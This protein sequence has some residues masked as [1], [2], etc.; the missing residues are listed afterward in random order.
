MQIAN[1]RDKQNPQTNQV[2]IQKA[3]TLAPTEN[4]KR[5]HLADHRIQTSQDICLQQPQ[6][7]SAHPSASLW[8]HLPLAGS[9]SKRTGTQ[10]Y[11]FFL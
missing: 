10:V 8:V 7:Q 2:G 11:N 5:T 6:P 4:R 9:Q 1:R 3:H